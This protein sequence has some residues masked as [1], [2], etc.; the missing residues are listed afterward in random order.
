[1]NTAEYLDAVRVKLTLPSDYALQKPLGLSKA[2]LS[3][4]R[5]GIDSLSDPV[6]L[7]VAEILGV[8]AGRVLLDMHMERSKSPEVKAAWHA[9]MEKFSESFNALML[10]TGACFFPLKTAR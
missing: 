4:Y 2:Q 9:L 1:M 3:R 6:A 8:E 10:Q 7:R 5:T